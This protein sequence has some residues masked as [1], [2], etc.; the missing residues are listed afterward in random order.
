VDPADAAQVREFAVIG[1]TGFAPVGAPLREEAIALAIK[2]VTHPRC[3]GYT[4]F[5]DGLPVSAGAIEVHG[6]VAALFGLSVLT[7]YRARGIQ[8][9][10][11]HHRLL[12][13]RERGARIATIGSAPGIGTE[14]N[15]RRAGFQV[16]YTRVFMHR[17]GPGLEPARF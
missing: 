14:R 5:L 8:T 10:M 2:C 12:A 15:A 16:A 1:C 9:A 7:D 4:A 17:P 3:T 6:E 13:A 11:I